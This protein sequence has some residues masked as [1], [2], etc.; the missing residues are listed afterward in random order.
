MRLHPEFLEEL[1]RAYPDVRDL[2]ASTAA[3]RL[4]GY[5][6]GEGSYEDLMKE[7]DDLG[8]SPRRRES[9]QTIVRRQKGAASCTVPR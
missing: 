3:A 8:L 4:N 6:G 5:L 9:L 7:L 1:R 2:V